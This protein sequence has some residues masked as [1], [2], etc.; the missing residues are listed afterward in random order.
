MPIRNLDVDALRTFVAIAESGSFTRGGE[1]VYRNQSSV[2]LQIKRLE[3]QLGAKL[4]SRST[5][6][7]A[8]T[9]QGE[10]ALIVAKRMLDLNDELFARIVE[11]DLEGVLRLG[12]PED[13]ATT[14][15]P[16]A[17]ARFAQAYPQVELEV[18]CDLTLNLLMRFEAGGLDIV[19]TKR[20]PD[21]A[22]PLGVKVWREPLVWV[23]ARGT[24]GLA[25]G[26]APLVL[27]PPPCVYR[28]RAVSALEAQGL[29]WRQAYSCASLAG[30]HAA[31]RAGLGLTVLPRGMAPADLAI[32]EDPRLP[33]LADTE[34]AL[35]VR[36]DLSRPAARLADHIVRSLEG[37]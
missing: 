27:A 33:E 20:E 3:A 6:R 34:I 13:F 16:R 18:V 8:L 17:L 36:N 30:I 26:R 24:T 28:K 22:A 7:V 14:H 31:V 23:G 37:G 5:R 2:S 19:L 12:A 15:L 1:A 25:E 9:A 35:S 21:A 11:P 4:F 32:L 10:A 29:A